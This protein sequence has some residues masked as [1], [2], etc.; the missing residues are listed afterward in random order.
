M[1]LAALN[2]SRICYIYNI[3]SSLNKSVN[4]KKGAILEY[5]NIYYVDFTTTDR[6]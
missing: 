4:K 3:Y 5:F 1:V 2:C 6:A